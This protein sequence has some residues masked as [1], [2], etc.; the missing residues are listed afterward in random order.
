MPISAVGSRKAILNDISPS[1]ISYNFNTA[2]SVQEFEQA[3]NRVLQHVDSECRWLYKTLHTDGTTGKINY[4][5]WSDVFICSYCSGE[6]VFWDVAV[7]KDS[8]KV[9][10][11]FSCPHCGASLTKRSLERLKVNVFD[12]ATGA[13]ISQ[14]KIVP[15]LINY[16]VGRKK[17]EKVPDARSYTIEKSTRC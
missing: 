4:T 8:G 12:R 5:V 1:F 10:Q 11:K 7:N 15:V 3:A 9:V 16:S 17:F 6:M 14:A 2:V 13:T